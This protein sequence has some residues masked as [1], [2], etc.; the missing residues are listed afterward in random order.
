MA[1]PKT[2]KKAIRTPILLIVI[3][4]PLATMLLFNAVMRF[5][6]SQNA[7]R[8]LVSVSEAISA[9]A[10]NVQWE[11][12]LAQADLK[13]AITQLYTALRSAPIA[14]DTALFVY[15]PEGALLYPKA[16]GQA[17]PDT[18]LAGQ[19]A[20]RL[21]AMEEGRVYTMHSGSRQVFLMVRPLTVLRES[22]TLVLATQPLGAERLF[23]AVNTTLLILLG[24]EILLGALF[25]E[26]FSAR[27][28]R[29]IHSLAAF[30]RRIGHGNFAPEPQSAPSG[31][32][33][34]DEL[35]AGAA[36]MALRLEAY[37]HSQRTFLQNASHELKT[38]LMS[39]QGYAE[40]IESGVFPDSKQAARIISD[41]SKRLNVLV[42]ELLTLSR[43]E[44]QSRTEFTRLDLR[45]VLRE[46]VQ[47]LGGLSEKWGKR[48]LL[49]VPDVPVPVYAEDTL[50]S[51]AV[52]NI[53]G[54]CL[55]YARTAV[56]ISLLPNRGEAVVRIEDDGEGISEADLPHLFDR[57]YKGKGGNFGLGLAI[58]RSAAVRLGG[59]VRAY[60]SSS[61]AVFEIRLPAGSD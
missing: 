35:Y 2:V 57:F 12:V 61:G 34:L 54:N 46:Y 3:V 51:Q 38:P 56:T 27:L 6:F 22:V 50:L 5:Y 9:M 53:A 19:I 14:S 47:R 59:R 1:A 21:P 25:A 8:E 7:R 17:S 28:A 4:F 39:I 45:D 18:Q 20:R 37:D 44:N 32:L 13:A 31:V 52:M 15:G 48:L 58:A 10:G 41:E 49:S 24:L 16:D 40:G 55:R 42:E 36:D 60:N 26:R 11:S 29:P 30:M 33:E 43:I 23:R